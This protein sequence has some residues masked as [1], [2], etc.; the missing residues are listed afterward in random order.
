ML[1][2]PIVKNLD[3][4]KADVAHFGPGLESSAEDPF[5]LEAVE[6]AFGRRIVPAV[7]LSAH[8]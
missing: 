6:P 1:S 4:F 8:R 5:V 7:S 2:F 3:V